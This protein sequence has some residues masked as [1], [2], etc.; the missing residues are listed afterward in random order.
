MIF[1]FL[2][3]YMTIRLN[4]WSKDFFNAMENKNIDE[5]LFQLGVLFG[6]AGLSLLLFANQ[7]YL[8]GKAV[9]LWRRYMS[10]YYMN[11]WLASRCYYSDLFFRRIDNPDQRIAED[12]RIFPTLT[13][14][15]MFDFVDSVS[16]LGGFAIILWSLSE[17]YSVFGI[18]IPGLMFWLALLFVIVGS[19]LVHR[20]GYPLIELERKTQEYEADYRYKL[21]RIRERAKEISAYDGRKWETAAIKQSFEKVFDVWLREI[22]KKRQ[23]NYFNFGYAQI[24]GVV[25]Y[26]LAAPKYFSGVFKMGELMQT[27]SAFN[28]VRVALSWFILNYP[29]LSEWMAT[30]DRLTQ[31]DAVLNEEDESKGYDVLEGQDNDLILANVRIVLPSG[32]VLTDSLSLHIAEGE[33]V[34]LTGPSGVGKTTLLYML[35]NM[36]PFGSGKIILP[37]SR[38]IFFPQRAYLPQGTLYDVLSYPHAGQYISQDECSRILQA[39]ELEYL[40]SSADVEQDWEKILS[41]G[42]QQRISLARIWV[43]RPSWL[44]LDE[45][46]SAVDPVQKERLLARLKEEFP[47][48]S[49][50]SIEHYGVQS[51]FYDRVVVWNEWVDK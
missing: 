22:L 21:L 25:P 30:V 9:L 1:N 38:K 8:C 3:V 12:L 17:A 14:S 50:F 51:K 48:M 24:S 47:R 45:A 19:W 28:G 40:L 44:F 2:N 16:T 15:L 34:A 11:K 36:W 31:Y 23:L 43:Q 6:L 7:K 13:V 4:I 29:A 42:E 18:V 5:F 39:V 46:L 32:E 20:I 33:K 37:A 49:V 41:P 10:G 27:V 35:R 26:L